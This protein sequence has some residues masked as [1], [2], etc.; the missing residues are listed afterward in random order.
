MASTQKTGTLGAIAPNGAPLGVQ[1]KTCGDPAALLA[2]LVADGA[3]PTQAH[4][5]ALAATLGGDINIAVNLATV[6]TL[7]KL[8]RALDLAY[9]EFAS[10]GQFTS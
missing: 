9:A 4:V 7:N 1:F 8:K 6:N 3:S 2:T 10:S 5:T